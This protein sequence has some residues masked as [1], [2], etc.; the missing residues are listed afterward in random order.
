MNVIGW[1]CR[2]CLSPA[3]HVAFFSV[4]VSLF[5]AK[6][7][8][9]LSLLSTRR[10]S[11]REQIEKKQLDWLATNT[12]DITSQSHSL[13]ACEKIA[14]WKTGLS[15]DRPGLTSVSCKQ[16]LICLLFSGRVRVASQ[17]QMVSQGFKDIEDYQGQDCVMYAVCLF[18][19]LL[20]DFIFCLCLL[21]GLFA[22][23]IV[24]L[25]DCLIVWLFDC[26]LVCLFPCL[27]VCFRFC[28]FVCLLVCYVII[29]S[30]S[31][32]CS[33]LSLGALWP[34]RGV[35]RTFC[36]LYSRRFG[37]RNYYF[38]LWLGLGGGGGAETNLHN[39]V[40]A[41][42]TCVLLCILNFIGCKT[43]TCSAW[44]KRSGGLYRW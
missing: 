1:W 44:S 8:T 2:Q 19:C 9:G 22:C 34:A 5:I 6:W 13:F 37:K 4:R 41:S 39:V 35:A 11:S 42:F 36:R 31:T 12:D 3:N 40:P 18:V 7:K 16:G 20:V 14:K 29:Y 17:E 15:F 28:L 10:I 38:F 43:E 24:L 27:F 21:L 32:L 33:L 25:F 26:L 23:F 30:G